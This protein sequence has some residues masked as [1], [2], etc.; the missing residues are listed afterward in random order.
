RIAVAHHVPCE[1]CSYCKDGHETTCEQLRSTNI[2]PGGFAEFIRVPAA[3]VQN[4]LHPLPN[5]MSY[6]TGTFVEPLGCV[7]RGQRSANI[8]KDDTLLIIGC[9]I[10]G[11]LHLKL[12]LT[13]EVRRVY[14]TDV[15][16]FRLQ[17][18][19][20]FGASVTINAKD[21]PSQAILATRVIVCTGSQDALTR[22]L[23]CLDRG[24]VM[25][26]FAGPK[27]GV[28]MPIAMPTL[29]DE[30]TF[31]T[32]YGASPKNMHEAIKMLT[33]KLITVED[34]VTHKLPLG[35]AQEGFNLT[36]KPEKSLKIIICPSEK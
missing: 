14:M 8:R 35:K 29:K 26:Y 3:N 2:D 25:L 9:G 24:G 16:D 19:K 34:M 30:I 31:T 15:D 33:D 12:A 6:E 20:K 1:N 5:S 7:I 36:V 10:T 4:G 11:I 21:G 22:G 17:L 27:S 23:S 18:A 28:S 32:S 13:K